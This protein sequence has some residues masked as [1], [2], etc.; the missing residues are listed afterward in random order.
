MIKLT[1]DEIIEQELESMR[2]AIGCELS[3]ND[4]ML[5]RDCSKELQELLQPL[6]ES[7]RNHLIQDHIKA[8]NELNIFGDD[9]DI[10]FVTG[11]IETQLDEPE[12]ELEDSTDFYIN[13]DLVYTSFSGCSYKVDLEGLKESINDFIE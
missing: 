6:S 10:K 2:E 11:E 4:E 7:D 13:G 8:G 1:R 3:L 9:G 12:K 5:K